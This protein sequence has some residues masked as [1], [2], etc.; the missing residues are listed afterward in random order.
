MFHTST[1]IIPSKLP[2]LK[3]WHHWL[4]VK[5]SAT[6]LVNE[7]HYPVTN[8]LQL[9]DDT[10]S[11]LSW[12]LCLK[13]KRALIEKCWMFTREETF[14]VW[15]WAKYSLSFTHFKPLHSCIA[16]LSCTTW[17]RHNRS[18]TFLRKTSSCKWG[19][20]LTSPS[21]APLKT[22]VAWYF[23]RKQTPPAAFLNAAS[24]VNCPHLMA[25][26]FRLQLSTIVLC[27]KLKKPAL[28]CLFWK[29][30]AAVVGGVSLAWFPIKCIIN[31]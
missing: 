25:L 3:L 28:Y 13:Q 23:T 19:L 12:H 2:H 21:A 26:P 9:T 15:L 24:L 5:T 18:V 10:L 1:I 29:G 4:V 17:L 30:V 22:E 6:F 11:P 20:W 31:G 16:L 7:W 8:I 27:K 14:V